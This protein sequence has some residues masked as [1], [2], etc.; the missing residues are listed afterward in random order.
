MLLTWSLWPSPKLHLLSLGVCRLPLPH[1]HNPGC[2][3]PLW[4]LL[5]P[6]SS[7]VTYNPYFFKFCLQLCFT[8]GCRPPIILF[9][10]LPPN[11]RAPPVSSRYMCS[12]R[13]G[14]YVWLTR[15]PTWDLS[16]ANLKWGSV[17]KSP[18]NA[19]NGE[20]PS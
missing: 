4:V 20:R 19:D 11:L 15:S 10:L 6:Y 16:T 5:H 13:E 14:L 12:Y 17:V 18:R 8:R 1:A 3:L 9:T 7:D 2:Q